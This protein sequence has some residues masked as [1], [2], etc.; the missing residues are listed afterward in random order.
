MDSTLRI[1]NPLTQVDIMCSS[2]SNVRVKPCGDSVYIY[3][4]PTSIEH[5]GAH[6]VSINK[7]PPLYIYIFHFSH[8]CGAFEDD[9]LTFIEPQGPHMVS[10][11]HPQPL[12]I[13]IFRFALSQ[14]ITQRSV[15]APPL[16]AHAP[17]RER[18]SA[19]VCYAQSVPAPPRGALRRQRPCVALLHG[20][21]R[22]QRAACRQR[23][24]VPQLLQC[25]HLRRRRA[26]NSLG[27][28]AQVEIEST[29]EAKIDKSK[30]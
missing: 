7:P 27:L 1:T 10:T 26:G 22:R 29:V 12:Y 6:M 20:R 13:H 25:V 18:P 21:Q 16:P 2:S 3:L 30:Q 15:P 28:A 24:R 23:P 5:K 9:L 11:N 14:S 4:L 17:C 19:P 8:R